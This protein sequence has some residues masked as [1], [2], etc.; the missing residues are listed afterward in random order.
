[1]MPAGLL[2]LIRGMDDSIRIRQRVVFPSPVLDP[3]SGEAVPL[4]SPDP[5]QYKEGQEDL[6]IR[7]KLILNYTSTFIK[8]IRFGLFQKLNE[9]FER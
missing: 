1:M 3:E 9:G 8:L 4:R 7:N 6:M 5:T 2:R